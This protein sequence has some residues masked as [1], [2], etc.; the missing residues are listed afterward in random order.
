MARDVRFTPTFKFH[1]KCWKKSHKPNVVFV[2][3]EVNRTE[4]AQTGMSHMLEL[5][6]MIKISFFLAL[7]S[8]NRVIQFQRKI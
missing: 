3:S 6:L 5:R 1:T 7:K 8:I 4:F 2:F